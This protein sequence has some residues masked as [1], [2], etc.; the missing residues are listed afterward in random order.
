[1]SILA[2]VVPT[3]SGSNQR[4]PIPPEELNK[5]TEVTQNLNLADGIPIEKDSNKLE[6]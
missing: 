3:V 4:N 6:L 5:L 2:N 1:M